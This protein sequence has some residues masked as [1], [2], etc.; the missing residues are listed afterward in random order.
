MS[1]GGVSLVEM[2]SPRRQLITF[3]AGTFAV[4]AFL[5]LTTI[6]LVWSN[7]LKFNPDTRRFEQ[8]VVVAVDNQEKEKDLTILINGEKV[9]T[10]IPFQKRNLVP[11]FYEVQISKEGFQSWRQTFSLQAGQVGL[12][13]KYQTIAVK[14]TIKELE[15]PLK[16]ADPLFETG[17][18]LSDDGELTDRGKLVTRFGVHPVI[19]RRFNDGYLYQINNE[20]RLFF[21]DGPQDFLV[22]QLSTQ[23][24][25]LL[26]TKPSA[27]QVYLSDNG[28]WKRIDLLIPQVEK[29]AGSGQ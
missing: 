1:Q 3:L 14:P 24:P 20:L 13:D 7:G 2:T 18:S 28:S 8:T 22:Y 21:I 16:F 12:I 19:A 9:G 5:V 26:V 23:N 25:A 15:E 10:E 17:L 27:W 6:A 29:S 4:I 11:G